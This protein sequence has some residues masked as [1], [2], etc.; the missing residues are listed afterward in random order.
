MAL[1]VSS[2]RN[3]MKGGG[4]RP[5]LFRVRCFAPNWVGFPV[6][7]FTFFANAAS[8]PS[9]QIGEKIIPYMGQDIKFAGD[10]VYPDYVLTVLNDEDFAIRNAFEKWNNGISQFSRTDA[11]RVDGATAD[12]ASYIGKIS[13]DQLGKGGEVIK[14]Y[15]LLNAWP[16]YI[17]EV[18]LAW[19][20]KDDIEQFSVS[21]RY[22]SISSEGVT[23]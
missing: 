18:Q 3:Q 12:P 11:V 14:T 13:I 19:A 15:S 2:F 16:A 20:A 4:A 9:S 1:N 5:S 23:T 6:E 22:D 17:S 21:F 10:R 7:S 8:L